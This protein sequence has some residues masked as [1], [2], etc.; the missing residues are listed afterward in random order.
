MSTNFH[1]RRRHLG[2]DQVAPFFVSCCTVWWMLRLCMEKKK[3]KSCIV[4]W[5]AAGH[6]K[7]T[8]T[9]CSAVSKLTLTHQTLA[10]NRMGFNGVAFCHG[11]GACMFLLQLYTE[12]A[13]SFSHLGPHLYCG[14]TRSVH[15]NE[16]ECLPFPWSYVAKLRVL[17]LFLQD[18]RV[19]FFSNL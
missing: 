10:N 5:S 11:P 15:P 8:H 6:Q 19:V 4:D 7:K 14:L 16:K 12:V 2:V 17:I 9:V 3:D 13:A 1:V 18:L